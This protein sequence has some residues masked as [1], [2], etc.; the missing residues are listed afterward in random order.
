MLTEHGVGI[1]STKPPPKNY[2][3]RDY[4][5]YEIKNGWALPFDRWALSPN[6]QGK[7]LSFTIRYKRKP[8]EPLCT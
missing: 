5:E 1:Y 6:G 2:A 7:I 8:N 3:R 4:K